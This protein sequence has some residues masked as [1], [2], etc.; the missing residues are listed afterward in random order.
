MWANKVAT[1]AQLGKARSSTRTQHY[2]GKLVCFARCGVGRLRHTTRIND[3]P[4][5]DD[6]HFIRRCTGEALTL[7]EGVP[8]TDPPQTLLR[9]AN[10]LLSGNPDS[11]AIEIAR[12]LL[13]HHGA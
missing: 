12:K 11:E 13:E 1:I 5:D 8:R 4:T 6:L 7:L 3:S 9:A 10:G 2:R